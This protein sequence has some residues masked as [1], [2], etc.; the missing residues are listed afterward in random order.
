[1]DD[2]CSAIEE[3]IVADLNYFSKLS[4]VSSLTP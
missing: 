4:R 2:V 1:M 3:N